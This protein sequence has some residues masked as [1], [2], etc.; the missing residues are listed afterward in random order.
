[1]GFRTSWPTLTSASIREAAT[2][3]I[4]WRGSETESVTRRTTKASSLPETA[5][6]SIST[7]WPAMTDFSTEDLM[8]STMRA[9]ASSFLMFFSFSRYW[10]KG[11]MSTLMGMGAGVR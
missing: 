9:Q 5:S 3:L 4:S 1:M 7:F 6:A 2:G 11:L 8:A 10:R